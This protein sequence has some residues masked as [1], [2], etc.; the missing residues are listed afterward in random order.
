MPRS[1]FCFT[2][3][4]QYCCGVAVVILAHQIEDFQIFSTRINF[5]RQY[6][7]H[8]NAEIR[9]LFYFCEYLLQKQK[10]CLFL[11]FLVL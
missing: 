5:L 10:F 9:V 4:N 1:E 2:F 8:K 7:E 11:N 3:C 6:T